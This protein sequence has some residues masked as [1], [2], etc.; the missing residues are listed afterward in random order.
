MEAL[1][2]APAMASKARELA[3]KA[4]AALLQGDFSQATELFT[5]NHDTLESERSEY[6]LRC[7]IDD[8]KWLRGEL[9]KLSEKQQEYLSTDWVELLFDAAR[10]ARATRAKGRI[11]RIAKILCSSIRIDPTPP[12][13]QTEEIMRIATALTDD[14]VLV[15]RELRNEFQRYEQL[16]STAIHTLSVPT[17]KDVPPDS[18]LGICGKLQ[19]LGLIATPEQHAVALKRGSY[20]TGGGFVLLDRA[21]AFLK[22]IAER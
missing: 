8:L 1:H 7:V 13:D 14:D 12:A 16:P 22:F 2:H 3:T 4:I 10:K 17:L 6:L 11:E 18:V 21:E 15:L 20:P 9:T 5:D 19:S